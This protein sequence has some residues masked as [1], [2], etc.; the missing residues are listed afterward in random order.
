MSP[1]E[2]KSAVIVFAREPKDG[3]V[4]TRLLHNFSIQDV[5]CLYKAFIKDVLKIVLEVEC[6]ERFIFYAGTGSSIPFLRK[7]Q[8]NFLLR[9]QMGK[10]L[11]ERMFR[12]FVQC[13]KEGFDKMIIIGTDCL[14]IKSIDIDKAFKKLEHHSCVLGPAK[15]GGYYLIGLKSPD[16][17]FFEK[18]KWSTSSVFE[19]T[20]G[21]IKKQKKTVA[22]LRQREDID[23]IKSLR[24]FSRNIENQQI[25]PF[26][27]K[28]SDCLNF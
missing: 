23:T 20:I 24:R 28:V 3:K 25:A 13:Q 18:I 26:T 15:D 2:S 8:R 11:G 27:K 7:F 17:R 16:K 5:T 21:E 12:A 9:R 22:L 10:D 6:D 19:Q 1:K 14:T 4:K